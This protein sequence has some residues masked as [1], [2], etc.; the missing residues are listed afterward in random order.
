MLSQSSS[1]RCSK[2]DTESAFGRFFHFLH[3]NFYFFVVSGIAL[4]RVLP[5]T[6]IPKVVRCNLPS[7][8]NIIF[9]PHS[10]PPLF[11]F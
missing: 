9:M 2:G 11:R 1:I 10:H 4:P 7:M 6:G 8:C 5:S 3:T